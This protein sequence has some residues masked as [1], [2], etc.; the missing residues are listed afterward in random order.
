VQAPIAHN[1]AAGQ[2]PS[3][4]QATA[5]GFPVPGQD[6]HLLELRIFHGTLGPVQGPGTVRVCVRVLQG[7]VALAA[8]IPRY[9]LLVDAGRQTL[10]AL[11]ASDR[12]AAVLAL[13]AAHNATDAGRTRE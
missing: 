5:S 2:W 8:S 10:C 7:C 13:G 4:F 3:R 12:E 1:Q 9:G 6:F 11:I